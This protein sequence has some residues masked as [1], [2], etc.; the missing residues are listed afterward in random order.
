MARQQPLA[1]EPFSVPATPKRIARIAQLQVTARP[2]VLRVPLKDTRDVRL[3]RLTAVWLHEISP[4]PPGEEP[5]DWMLFTNQPVESLADAKAVARSYAQRWRI[6]EIHKAW[7]S[8]VCDVEG[9][10]LRSP[11]TIMK[12]ATISIAVATRVE[13]LKRLARSDPDLP[14]TCELSKYELAALLLLKRSE[15]KRTEQVPD[16]PTIAQ[17]TRWIADLGG[18]TG[19]SSGGPPGSIT[20]GRGFSRVEVAAIVLEQLDRESK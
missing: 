16:N 2:V 10:K 9:T 8:G 3:L 6:E 14:A 18:Y 5:L 7:K 13:R 12:W 4:T 11:G 17:A 15:K 20:I 1:V 19:K